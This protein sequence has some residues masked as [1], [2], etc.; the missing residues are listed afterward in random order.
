MSTETAARRLA[1]V[2]DSH[3]PDV[4]GRDEAG[5]KLLAR[6]L[7]VCKEAGL[8]VDMDGGKHRVA[9]WHPPVYAV[10]LST[11]AGDIFIGQETINGLEYDPL[12]K[13]IT[14]TGPEGPDALDVIAGEVGAALDEKARR[15]RKELA[16]QF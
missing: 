13:E 11:S 5:R 16:V 2:R 4:D 9:L 15:K 8:H 10:F 6:F 3:L 7:E 12:H 14:G 1:K